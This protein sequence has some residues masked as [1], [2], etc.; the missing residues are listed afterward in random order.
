DVDILLRHEWMRIFQSTIFLFFILLAISYFVLYYFF[1]HILP[2]VFSGFLLMALSIFALVVLP[3][4]RLPYWFLLMLTVEIFILWFFFIIGMMQSYLQDSLPLQLKDKIEIGSWMVATAL[5]GL[6]INE[7]AP[8]LHGF[9]ILLVLIAVS[10]YIIY[11]VIYIK[12]L[13]RI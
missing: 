1:R 13:M 3:E 11:F 8:F 7:V 4:F 10:L 12:S 5:I 6:L 9:L 2:H